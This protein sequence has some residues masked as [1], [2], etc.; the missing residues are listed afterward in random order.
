[1]PQFL[2]AATITSAC[3]GSIGMARRIPA[4]VIIRLLPVTDK[5]H[6]DLSA[7]YSFFVL[8]L[9]ASIFVVGMFTIGV[10][11]IL[12]QTP[13][14]YLNWLAILVLPI[15][16]LAYQFKEKNPYLYGTFEV[17]VGISMAF[18][19][20]TTNKAFQPTQAFTIISGIYVVARGSQDR[21]EGREKRK[22]H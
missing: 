13:G 6:D 19:A 18:G 2:N 14:R 4:Q 17:L 12:Y 20:T 5:Q 10:N 8:G 16:Y 3:S 1:M 22:R 11:R 15:G 9:A 7:S 21:A